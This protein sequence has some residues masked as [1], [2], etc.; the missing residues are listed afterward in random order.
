MVLLCRP[1]THPQPE[2]KKQ[3]K[4]GGGERKEEKGWEGGGWEV[5]GAIFSLDYA[6]KI[7]SQFFLQHII[8]IIVDD[9]KTM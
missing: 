1:P 9:M 3:R 4:K 8:S 7:H 6:C 5:R 2:Q